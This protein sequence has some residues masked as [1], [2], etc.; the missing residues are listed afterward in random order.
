M[1][2]TEQAT[3]TI[4]EKLEAGYS[5]GKLDV[6]E[7]TIRKKQSLDQMWWFVE[8]HVEGNIDIRRYGGAYDLQSAIALAVRYIDELDDELFGPERDSNA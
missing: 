7:W 4:K 8:A 5:E 2:I 1:I 3:K 6:F